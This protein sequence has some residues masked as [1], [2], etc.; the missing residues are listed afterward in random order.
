[1]HKIKLIIQGAGLDGQTPVDA[2]PEFRLVEGWMQAELKGPAGILPAGLW[3]QVPPGD[4]Y[5]LH[6]SMLSTHPLGPQSFLEVQSGEPVT[7]R[8]QYTPTADNTR[9]V[10]VRPSDRLRLFTPAAPLVKVELLVESIG[11]TGE[12]G[13]R[14]HDWATAVYQARDVGVRTARFQ[15]P[16][17]L[18][19]WIGTMHLIYDSPAAGPI[20]LPPRSLVPTNAV[21]TITRASGG[22]PSIVPA[23][24]DSLAGGLAALTV[25]RS[26]I[27]MNN[28]DQ[29]TWAG[30]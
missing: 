19:A 18:S 14:L 21:L 15:A 12:L 3:G 26:A 20:T 1:M 4:P 8:S 16:A 22:V 7:V 2:A 10:L 11:G 5:L 17:N 28:G 13:T 30:T 24:G 29:W 27:M 9:L 23:A 25:L 6:A